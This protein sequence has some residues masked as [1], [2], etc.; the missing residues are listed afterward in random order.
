VNIGL[1]EYLSAWQLLVMAVFIVGW[2]TG[3]GYL[4]RWSIRRR[5]PQRRVKLGKCV[6]VSLLA[7]AAGGISG[8]VLFALVYIIGRRTD[9]NLLVPGVVFGMLSMLT[10]SFLTVSVM[11]ESS[12]KS[13]LAA[14]G[15]SIAAILGWALLLGIPTTI[16]SRNLTLVRLE[17]ET[18]ALHLRYIHRGLSLYQTNFGQSPVN[19]TTL[20][21][22]KFVEAESLRCPAAPDRQIGYFYLPAPT[23]RDLQTK[24]ILACDFRENHG[25]AGRTVLLVNGQ[26]DW[27]TEDRFAALLGEAENAAFAKALREAE[28]R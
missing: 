6:L 8:A 15:P 28:G 11:L 13:T 1:R 5:E 25:G 9:T 2:L 17:R 4:L 18:C 19:L 24:Q 16:V 7:G 23:S 12:A 14:A 20:A 3:G 21:E 10:V 26:C 27:Y 22:K